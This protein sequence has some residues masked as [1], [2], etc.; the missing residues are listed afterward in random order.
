[1]PHL[2]QALFV[3]GNR[4]GKSHTDFLQSG[5]NSPCSQRLRTDFLTIKLV[6]MS[7]LLNH[8]LI[9]ILFLQLSSCSSKRVENSYDESKSNLSSESIQDKLNGEW[10]IKGI[11]TFTISLNNG[12]G[13][14]NG[15]S[16]SLGIENRTSKLTVL[17][18]TETSITIKKTGVTDDIGIY[19]YIDENTFSYTGSSE[20]ELK[21][22]KLK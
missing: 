1:M 19:K 22:E 21:L 6:K 17:N 20:I 11:G 15:T 10:E 5:F 13:L 16:Q 12:K 8:L 3:G 14:I 9:I 18:E 4:N 2:P 7:K